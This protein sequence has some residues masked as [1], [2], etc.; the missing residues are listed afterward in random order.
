MSHIKFNP[1][2]LVLLALILVITLFRIVVVANTDAFIWANFSSL[3]AVALFGGAYFSNNLKA[4]SFP[5]LSLF[6]SDL[7]LSTTVLKEYQRFFIEDWFWTYLAIALMVL[8]GKQLMKKINVVNFLLATIVGVLIHWIITD[9][10]VWY[11]NPVYTQDLAGYWLCLIKA[12]PFEL[13]FLQGTLMYGTIMFGAFELL[14]LKYPI[15]KRKE[16]LA[17]S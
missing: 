5:I 15:L 1:R 7:V 4:Y 3:G 14:K 9:L 13:R 12:I 10:G 16:S 17:I 2:T 6:L 11:N 8:V